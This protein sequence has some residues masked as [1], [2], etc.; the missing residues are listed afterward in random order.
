[1]VKTKKNR[2]IKNR[3]R[4]NKRRKCIVYGGGNINKYFT[5]DLNILFGNNSVDRKSNN[6]IID[7]LDLFENFKDIDEHFTFMRNISLKNKW[8]FENPANFGSCFYL[9]KYNNRT[10]YKIKSNCKIS[11]VMESWLTESISTEC[12]MAIPLFV[13]LK[14][15]RLYGEKINLIIK[16]ITCN[17]CKS[18]L[19][20]FTIKNLDNKQLLYTYN[21]KYYLP[22]IK[23]EETVKLLD[24]IDDN[25]CSYLRA[26]FG[27]IG[28][29]KQKKNGHKFKV[30]T[31][32]QGHNIFI[33]GNNRYGGFS[34]IDSY[35]K[36]KS[37]FKDQ[38]GYLIWGNNE[39]DNHRLKW[40]NG[41][42]KKGMELLHENK[43]NIDL[44]DMDY[45]I[46]DKKYHMNDFYGV[47]NTYK[48]KYIL[49]SSFKN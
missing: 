26:Q 37:D 44:I 9:E 17:V 23:N 25:Y 35:S 11:D 1:M 10:I 24:S 42:K 39:D 48:I 46:Q 32:A 36:Y 15:Y 38:A 19:G 6:K 22:Q 28:L 7:G 45:I 16:D 14:I 21:N 5:N 33:L 18:S 20:L 12:R 3:K 30:P 47:I 4:I 49:P 31:R 41:C 2:T 8:R 34:A 13:L 43:K 27:Y 29:D 40:I